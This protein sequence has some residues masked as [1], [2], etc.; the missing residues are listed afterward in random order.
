LFRRRQAGY[1]RYYAAVTHF[2]SPFFQSDWNIL[3]WLRDQSLPLLPRIPWV[4]RQ[5][6]M[7]VAGLKGG[8]LKGRRP[9]P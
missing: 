1:H 8:F 7:T 3:G 6:L 2:L 5:M 4:K 9:L